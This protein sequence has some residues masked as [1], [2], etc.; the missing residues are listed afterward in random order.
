MTWRLG[1]GHRHLRVQD[2]QTYMVLH[3]NKKLDK[4]WLNS[5]RY[6]VSPLLGECEVVV[7]AS[8]TKKLRAVQLMR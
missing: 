4:F 6:G 7:E 5:M 2:F 1:D 3:R 8:D